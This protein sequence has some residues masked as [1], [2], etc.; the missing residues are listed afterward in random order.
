MRDLTETTKQRTVAGSDISSY[1][2]VMVGALVAGNWSMTVTSLSLGL[3]LP[4]ITES[5]GLSDL[6]GG[7]L[8]SSVRLGNVLMALPAALLLSKLN[9]LRMSILSVFAAAVFTFLHGL[10]PSFL[11]LLVARL[12]FG[13]S[14]T[15]RVPA[16][17]LLTQQWFPLREIPLING[18][19]I[20]LTG[21]AE[22]FALI[23]TPLILTLTGSWRQTYHVYGFIALAVFFLWLF[24]GR[25]RS[26][27]EFQA[28]IHS[29]PML[30]YR[31]MFR[32]PQLWLIGLGGAG[33]TFG[34]WAFGTFWPTYM[35]EAHQFS[36]T[37]SGFLFSLISIAMIPSSM[38][39]GFFVYKIGKRRLILASCGLLMAG[40]FLGMIWTT[41]LW[42]LV[43]FGLMGGIAWGFAPIAIS[44][45]Y[46]IPGIRPREVAIGASVITT[47]MLGGG[48]LGPVTAGAVSDTTG[49]LYTGLL[50][51][52]FMPLTLVLVSA[53]L[54]EGPTRAEGRPDGLL[55]E[56]QA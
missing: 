28:R 9:P 4:A 15:L 17:A 51:C 13:L 8:G 36:L 25:E 6:Q 47:M 10:A 18:I 56:K 34:W 24:L 41:Q 22:A 30:S 27:P 55:A 40:A 53:F 49:S 21:V 39:I 38:L 3:L 45:P 44:M 50:V 14:F 46:E 1:R 37:R 32:Y 52:G 54:R 26:T 43:I 5:L 16:R 42:A 2:W 7:W 48:I 35:L 33:T 23:A 12:G 29:E 31:T 20:G 19:I 11:F